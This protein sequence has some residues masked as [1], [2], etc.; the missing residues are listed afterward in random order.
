MFM[1]KVASGILVKSAAPVSADQAMVLLNNMRLPGRLSR[2]A[3]PTVIGGVLGGLGGHYLTP[4]E[5][6]DRRSANTA[7]GALLGASAGA[8]AGWLRRYR[9]GVPAFE[10]QGNRVLMHQNE[11]RPW[12]GVP[13]P[14]IKGTTVASPEIANELALS[15]QATM[16][17]RGLLERLV[18]RAAGVVEEPK[19]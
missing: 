8:G 19:V 1:L 5:S 4:P 9:S 12:A 10:S 3:A 13:Y 2:F 7:I 17:Q 16:G 14:T 6:D 11:V 15:S 18:N